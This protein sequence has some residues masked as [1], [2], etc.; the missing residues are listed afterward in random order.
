MSPM[1][2]TPALC[3]W[4]RFKSGMQEDRALSGIGND[5]L[6]ES[7]GYAVKSLFHACREADVGIEYI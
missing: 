7:R 2:S 6:G 3:H 5:L 1:V 4:E